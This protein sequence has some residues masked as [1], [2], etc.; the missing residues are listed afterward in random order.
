MSTTIRKNNT[1]SCFFPT[2][3]I[4]F[5]FESL[6][7]VL[8]AFYSFKYWPTN[9]KYYLLL[10]ERCVILLLY[11]CFVVFFTH[12][13]KNRANPVLK[14][15]INLG[16]LKQ[17]PAMASANHAKEHWDRQHDISTRGHCR[18]ELSFGNFF[19]ACFHHSKNF[20]LVWPNKN[21][22]IK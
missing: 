21:P 6:D 17:V 4:Y 14:T 18:S 1:F 9:H 8:A 5:S 7:S 16:Y 15:S 22:N 2:L 10:F 12:T 13:I 19:C 3:H 11:C 20:F